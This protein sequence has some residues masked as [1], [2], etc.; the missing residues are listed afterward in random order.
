MNAVTD[1]TENAVCPE[2]GYPDLVR[3][4][5]WVR[6]NTDTGDGAL[7]VTC[8]HRFPVGRTIFRGLRYPTTKDP[9]VTA[10]DLHHY[11]YHFPMTPAQ[12]VTS[13]IAGI[14]GLVIGTWLAIV[15]DNWLVGL[16]FFPILYLGWW[17]GHW[18]S[19]PKRVI[20]GRC[21][22]CQYNLRGVAGNRCPECGTEIRN[23]SIPER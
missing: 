7:C 9:Y 20:P 23:G 21:P 4:R 3:T 18:I 8:G 22:K 6:G 1:H 19:P 17:V 12:V 10:S 11:M 16:I 15:C 2:C 5:V 13:C 14:L